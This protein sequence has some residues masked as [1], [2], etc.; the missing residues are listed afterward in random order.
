MTG[1]DRLAA[2]LA[3]HLALETRDAG[4][5]TLAASADHRVRLHAGP[6]S[7]GQCR[8]HRFVHTR[9]EIDVYPAG[10]SDEWHQADASVGLVVSLAPALVRRVAEEAGRDPAR[11]EVAM[12]HQIR[13]P[14]LEHIA[15]ALEAERAAGHPGGALFRES[16][17]LA[18]AVR[19]LGPVAAP[20]RPARGLTSQQLRAV[21]AYIEDHLDRDLSLAT[22]AEV[23][24]LSASH[25]K[26]LFRRS[27]GLPVHTYVI[28]R[29]VDRAR[30]MLLH[31]RMAASQVA[32]EVGFSHQSHM[33]RCMRRVLG[34]TP[35]SL[36]RP[37]AS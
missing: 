1:T 29:R 37:L 5:A 35:T 33:A 25:F 27:L 17:G 36:T 10:T 18:L 34:V 21:T 15:W 23:A 14:Q 9:G 3:P 7:H 12:R 32:L 13:D 22:L 2:P 4:L 31:G 16:L 6:P 24:G 26:T 20:P 19:L 28:H 11:V 8:H 30:A